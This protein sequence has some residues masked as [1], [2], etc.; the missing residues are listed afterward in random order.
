VILGASGKPI[1]AGGNGLAGTTSTGGGDTAVGDGDAAAVDLV[2][3]VSFDLIEG[4]MGSAI[5]L[6]IAVSWALTTPLAGIGL[7][8]YRHR[9]GHFKE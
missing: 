8:R 7:D 3:A 1:A 4:F 5:F 2:S 9:G 6:A